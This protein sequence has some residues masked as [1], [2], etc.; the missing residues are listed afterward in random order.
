MNKNAEFEDGSSD[1]NPTSSQ[2]SDQHQSS[3]VANDLSETAD[4]NNTTET[5]D[6]APRTMRWVNSDEWIE[7]SLV[8][9]LLFFIHVPL[10]VTPSKDM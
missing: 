3:T 1:Q 10:H 8:L 4:V 9:K 6:S 7:F 5:S 2:D